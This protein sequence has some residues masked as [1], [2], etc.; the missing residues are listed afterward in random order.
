MTPMSQVIQFSK[1]QVAVGSGHGG[2]SIDA[3]ARL[4]QSLKKWL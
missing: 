2:G 1:K 3:M 4:L